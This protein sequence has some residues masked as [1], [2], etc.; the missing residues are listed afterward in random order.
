[1][2]KYNET[3]IKILKN[4]EKEAKDLNHQYIG[5]E[6]FILSTLKI[7]N[8]IKDILNNLNI[9]YEKY[10]NE[11]NKIII[12]TKQNNLISY[13]PLFKRIL[14]SLS[15]KK[16]IT[17]KDVFIEILEYGEGIGLSIL[18]NL[19]IDLNK[20]YN[21]LLNNKQE[22]YGNNLN[23]IVN[24][25]QY[26]PIIGRDKEIN[27]IIEILLRKNKNNHLLIGNPGIGKTALVEALE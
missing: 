21:E 23:E 16:E 14:M 8:P 25:K 2:N 26:E 27:E 4:S 12:N 7:N 6:H 24:N 20:L 10:L 3:L 19:N 13:M 5:T 18:N 9:T 11:I 22:E 17:E 1:M 15:N